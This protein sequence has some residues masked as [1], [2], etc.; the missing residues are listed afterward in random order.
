MPSAYQENHDDTDD[1]EVSSQTFTGNASATNFPWSN[2]KVLDADHIKVYTVVIATGAATL[3]SSSDYTL[4]G[5]GTVSGSIDYPLVGSPLAATHQL[6][7]E[8]IVPYTQEMDISNQGA[9]LPEVIEAQLDLMVMQIQRVTGLADAVGDGI[10]ATITGAVAGPTS[11]VDERF[12]R[13]NGTGGNVLE[14][15][16]Y[17]AASFALASHTH[18]T[19]NIVSPTAITANQNDYSPT[20][21]ASATILRISSDAV[22]RQ[23]TGLATGAADRFIVL[24]NVG[25]YD[26]TL[27]HENASSS[28]AELGSP[29]R[30]TKLSSSRQRNRWNFITTQ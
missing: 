25:S 17:T 11:S 27:R 9:F 16:G 13:F 22:N 12:A 3:L 30:I 20:N 28:A 2:M 19:K 18:D 10:V 21:L 6:L 24:T 23:I 1:F 8:R 29:F 14:D 4:N 5:V 26:I 7:V 15:S